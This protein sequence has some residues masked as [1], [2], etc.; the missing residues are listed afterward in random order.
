MVVGLVDPLG[1]IHL[2]SAHKGDLTVKGGSKGRRLG[3][4]PRVDETEPCELRGI[5]T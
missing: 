5:D 3:L 1:R 2:I 4:L